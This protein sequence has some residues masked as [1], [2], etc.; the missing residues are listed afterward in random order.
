MVS[1][2]LHYIGNLGDF[3]MAF[4]DISY[5]DDSVTFVNTKTN[6]A[7][8]FELFE[9][10]ADI[11][12]IRIVNGEIKARDNVSKASVSLLS[13][14]LD[15][16]RLDEYKGKTPINELIP[17]D[18]KSAIRDIETEYLKPIFSAPMIE[19]GNTMATIEK[20]WQLFASGLREGGGYANAKSRVIKYFAH[21]GKLPLADNGKCLTVASI[22]KILSNEMSKIVPDVKGGIADKLVK[23]SLEIENRKETTDLGDYP[24]AIAS[25]K[26]MLA[27]YEGLYRETLE[28]L[29]MA[30]GN[31]SLQNVAQMAIAKASEKPSIESID[32]QYQNGQID[33][34]TYQIMMLE[35][36]NIEIVLE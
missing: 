34:T 29:T 16:P 3:I 31:T 26:S 27:T 32:A 15:S 12:A 33:D 1:F 10:M 20:Q 35:H 36:H 7:E 17:N 23:L 6:K 18:L 8:K 9:Q 30:I 14:L 13:H 2:G 21:I 11:D 22:D 28:N 24:T 5:S 19:K 25:L 4:Y